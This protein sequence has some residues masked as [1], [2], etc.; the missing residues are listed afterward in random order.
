MEQQLLDWIQNVL[1][2][3]RLDGVM[4]FVSTLGD[5]GLIWIALALV[6]L[7]LVVLGILTMCGVL[8]D[9]TWKPA[10]SYPMT[11]AKVTWAG[12]GYNGLFAR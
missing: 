3:D 9:V 2:A 8:D 6:L 11:N 7:C 1:R 12:A 10:V 4:V 5:A